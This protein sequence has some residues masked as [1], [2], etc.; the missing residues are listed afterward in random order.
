M[1]N[2]KEVVEK[3]EAQL[4]TV[5]DLLRKAL[6]ILAKVKSALKALGLWDPLVQKLK[7]GL[8]EQ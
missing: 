4:E 5:T 1:S 8:F 7:S 6:A 2:I 3:E